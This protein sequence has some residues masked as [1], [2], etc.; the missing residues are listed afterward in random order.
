MAVAEPTIEQRYS[1]PALMRRAADKEEREALQAD[2]EGDVVQAESLLSR[3]ALL[4]ARADVWEHEPENPAAAKSVAYQQYLR[5]LTIGQDLSDRMVD[6][7]ERIEGGEVITWEQLEQA[8]EDV[9]E[10]HGCE[11]GVPTFSLGDGDEVRQVVL[12]SGVPLQYRLSQNLTIPEHAI[13][14]M[15]AGVSVRN[16]FVKLGDMG[17]SI[18]ELPNG[19]VGLLAE[20]MAG[21]RM[22]KWFDSFGAHAASSLTADAELRAMDT[23][24]GKINDQQWKSYVLTGAFAERS[25]RSDLH[26]VFRKGLP[27]MVMS[28]HGRYAEGGRVLACLCLHPMGY[29]RNTHAGVMTPTDEVIAHLL[30]MR[31]DEHGF[32]KK[33]GQWPASDTRSGL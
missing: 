22:R 29:Y 31:A 11:Y 32:W 20:P 30:F 23:L 14:L 18:V 3:A 33:S 9:S 12:A 2:A 1:G 19:R 21:W 4:R 25:E 24:K 16:S 13:R 28:W 8:F 7:A 15:E 10:D 27:T 26:Y 17:H 6:F 5:D